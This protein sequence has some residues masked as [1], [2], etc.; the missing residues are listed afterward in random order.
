MS[1]IKRY[2]E[3]VFDSYEIE[4]RLLDEVIHRVRSLIPK[5]EQ[6]SKE[7]QCAC[8]GGVI[9]DLLKELNGEIDE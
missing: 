6:E 3:S 1:E 2:M 4:I 9:K 8:Y 7:F 5:W